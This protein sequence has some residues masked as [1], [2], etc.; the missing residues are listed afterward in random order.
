MASIRKAVMLSEE[1]YQTLYTNGT[2][3]KTIDQSQV[4][5]VYDVNNMYFTDYLN[6][7]LIDDSNSTKKFVTATE[8]SNIA[9]IPDLATA[10]A[11]ALGALTIQTTAPTE[12]NT[13]GYLKVVYLTSQPSAKYNG[14]LYLIKA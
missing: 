10:I 2:I 1:D 7:E 4:T 13:S 14:Y 6:T 5:E 9:D 3:T 12:D 8:K 11:T